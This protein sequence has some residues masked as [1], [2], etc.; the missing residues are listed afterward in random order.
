MNGRIFPDIPNLNMNL[1]I[2]TVE[3]PR[4][5]EDRDNLLPYLQLF[6]KWGRRKLVD[7]KAIEHYDSRQLSGSQVLAVRYAERKDDCWWCCP[8]ISGCR[9][10]RSKDVPVCNR[11]RREVQRKKSK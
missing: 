11:H 7:H 5:W 6:V 2:R 3:E 8:I 1:L 9:S 4:E 10:L